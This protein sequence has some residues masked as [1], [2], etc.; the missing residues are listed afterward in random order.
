MPE[1]LKSNLEIFISKWLP[2]RKDVKNLELWILI[3]WDEI[4]VDN[5]DMNF[6]IL[7]MIVMPGLSF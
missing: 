5:F 3:S 2:Q 7:F 6:Q 4:T 1:S